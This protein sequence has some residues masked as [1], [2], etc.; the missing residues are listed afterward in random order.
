MHFVLFFCAAKYALAYSYYIVKAVQSKWR[1]NVFMN[2]NFRAQRYKLMLE[3]II[4]MNKKLL[5]GLT[6]LSLQSTRRAIYPTVQLVFSTG[7]LNN[8]DLILSG[9]LGNLNSS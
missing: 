1:E 2:M 8:M 7:S 3:N 5:W 6:E 4:E 9:E